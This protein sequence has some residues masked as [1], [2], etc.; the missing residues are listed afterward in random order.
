MPKFSK[1]TWGKFSNYVILYRMYI[2]LKL[3]A[4]LRAEK[5][6][7]VL[8]I[9]YSPSDFGIVQYFVFVFM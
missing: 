8:L 5:Q 3:V 2:Y 6:V 9:T 7:A 4:V 1:S